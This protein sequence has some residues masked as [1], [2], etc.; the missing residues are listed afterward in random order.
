[1][2]G[3]KYLPVYWFLSTGRSLEI[4]YSAI[5]LILAIT[6]IIKIVMAIIMKIVDSNLKM[7][8]VSRK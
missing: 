3:L 4:K 6:V 5:L 1:M 8:K 7:Y 2:S